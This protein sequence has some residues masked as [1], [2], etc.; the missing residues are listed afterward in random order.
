MPGCSLG[1][2]GSSQLYWSGHAT[3]T[4][5]GTALIQEMNRTGVLID[6]THLPE[7]LLTQLLN[8]RPGEGHRRNN[9]PIVTLHDFAVNGPGD[10]YFRAVAASGGGYGVVGFNFIPNFFAGGPNNVTAATVVA[11]MKDL[12]NRIGADHIVLGGDYYNGQFQFVPAT[13]AGM[14]ELTTEFVAQGFTDD[15]VRKVLGE[16]ML[17]AYDRA[18]DPTRG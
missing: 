1:G 8:G 9:A 13:V 12:K 6:V 7:V 14:G 10:A 18:W 5:Q 4:E 11:A 15:E 17:A 2:S 16:N 3:L